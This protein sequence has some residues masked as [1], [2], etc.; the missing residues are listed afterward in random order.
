[1]G[2]D[3]LLDLEVKVALCPSRRSQF[4][5]EFLFVPQL[6]GFVQKNRFGIVKVEQGFNVAFG[7]ILLE[8]AANLLRCLGRHASSHRYRRETVCPRWLA[9]VMRVTVSCAGKG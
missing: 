8:K 7:H 3:D 9:G 5:P 1:A 6:A 4:L 2:T